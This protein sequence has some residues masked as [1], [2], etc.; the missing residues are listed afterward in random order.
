M[1]VNGAG[2]FIVNAPIAD[3]AGTEIANGPAIPR[4]L[5]AVVP[6]VTARCLP[7]VRK[8][9]RCRRVL[10]QGAVSSDI[11]AALFPSQD[12][13]LTIC[14]K[15]LFVQLVLEAINGKLGGYCCL[16]GW[17]ELVGD[18]GGSRTLSAN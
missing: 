12:S 1:I 2:A 8:R 15:A 5:K 13:R 16:G 10:Q 6:Q 7:V 14:W 9:A 11:P 3:G 4:S 18:G 17:L